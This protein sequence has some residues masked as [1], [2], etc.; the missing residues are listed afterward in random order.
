[1]AEAIAPAATAKNPFVRAVFGSGLAGIIAKYRGYANSRFIPSP[2]NPT[3]N[4][5]PGKLAKSLSVVINSQPCAIWDEHAAR[6]DAAVDERRRVR[7]GPRQA[8]IGPE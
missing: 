6:D 8:T 4:R 5:K 7:N 2:I 3:K 1:L